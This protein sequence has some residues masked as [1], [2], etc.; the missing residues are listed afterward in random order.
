MCQI[1]DIIG[2]ALFPASG[3]VYCCFLVVVLLGWIWFFPFVGVFL[4]H[5]LFVRSCGDG[6]PY[7]LVY[8]SHPTLVAEAVVDP[9][10]GDTAT[11]SIFFA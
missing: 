8:R 9:F 5:S 2:V 1:D 11:A 3:V 10:F 4:A 6:C 7:G